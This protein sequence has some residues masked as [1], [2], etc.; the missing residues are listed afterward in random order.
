MTELSCVISRY[1][2]AAIVVAGIASAA[3]HSGLGL[4]PDTAYPIVLLCLLVVPVV[5]NRHRVRCE[6]R[7]HEPRPFDGPTDES[8]REGLRW[9]RAGTV[10]DLLVVATLIAV[11]AAIVVVL[12]GGPDLLIVVNLMTIE[13]G[14]SIWISA[15]HSRRW[16][17]ICWDG[18]DDDDDDEDPEPEPGPVIENRLSRRR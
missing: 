1:V 3:L 17:P 11:I 16:C 14:A 9:H 4:L 10:V 12:R 5:F 2:P 7:C 15:R 18:D 8:R 13:V 6:F